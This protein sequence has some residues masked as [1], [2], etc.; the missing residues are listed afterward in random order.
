MSKIKAKPDNQLLNLQR[1]FTENNLRP[2][3]ENKA[4]NHQE[5][6]TGRQIKKTTPAARK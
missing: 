2:L 3:W 6:P 4:E 5:P 1:N